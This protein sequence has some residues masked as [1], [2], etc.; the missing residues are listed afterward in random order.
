M[1]SRASEESGISDADDLHVNGTAKCEQMRFAAPYGGLGNQSSDLLSPKSMDSS[2][3]RT[4][5]G[6]LEIRC[7]NNSVPIGEETWQAN[8]MML[9]DIAH[10]LLSDSLLSAG[11]DEQK[12]IAHVNSMHSLLEKDVSTTHAS[13]ENT[14]S[15]E[16]SRAGHGLGRLVK[17]EDDGQVC[18]INDDMTEAVLRR[19]DRIE[20]QVNVMEDGYT[21]CKPSTVIPRQDSLADLLVNIPRIASFPQ[22]FVHSPDELITSAEQPGTTGWNPFH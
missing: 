4:V 10:H 21:D 5:S 16:I 9:D 1:D 7:A 20:S 6:S 15:L 17:R 2:V 13:N 19:D 11:C 18:E 12:V 8:K 14:E 3:N 22:L